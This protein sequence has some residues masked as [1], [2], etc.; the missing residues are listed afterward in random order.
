MK[1]LVNLT[2][3]VTSMV[4]KTGLKVR[5]YSPEILMAAGAVCIVGGVVCAIKATL[6]VEENVIEVHEDKKEC[7][8]SEYDEIPRQELV[9]LYTHTTFK[10]V[11]LYT[12]TLALEATG[13]VCMLAANNILRK[14]LGA[15]TA[16]YTAVSGAFE[17]YRERVRNELGHEMDEHFR[18]GTQI[19]KKVK[20][21]DGKKVEEVETSIGEEDAELI[22]NGK[23][24]Y[25]RWFDEAS[26]QWTKD[27]S[28]NLSYILGKQAYFNNL[29][30]VRGYVFLN[31]V[32][33]ELG[34]PW[35]PEGQVVGWLEDHTTGK[36]D[37]GVHEDQESYRNF[38]NGYTNNILLDFNVDGIIYDKI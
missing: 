13:I 29:L 31:E 4:G 22:K 3:K 24:Q 6:K 14:R 37:F 17:K 15:V 26:D 35:T 34:I 25:A 23:S 33:E 1:P 30:Q 5:K 7:L 27:A 20:K 36:I 12:P 18:Y 38:V 32:Y 11:K 19:S 9:K 16:A 21:I 2:S 28:Y 8:A 10:L